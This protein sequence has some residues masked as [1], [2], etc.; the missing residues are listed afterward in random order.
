MLFN[1]IEYLVFLPLVIVI[2]FIIP[3]KWRWL[4]LLVASYFFYMCNRIEYGILILFTTLVDYFVALKI[5]QSSSRKRKKGYLAI[6]LIA[7]LGMLAGFKYLNFFGESV[8]LLLDAFHMQGNLPA[9]RIL[10][11]VGIS[12]FVFKSL[13]YTIDVYRGIRT[14]EKHL[15]YYALYVSFFPQLIAGP[16]DRSSGLLQQFHHP[17]DFNT[18]RLISGLK[19]ILWGFFKKVII[20]D[21]LGL[22]V[23]EI[24]AHPEA[25]TGLSVILATVLFAFQLYCDFAGYTDIA[26]GSARILGFDLMIN[27]NRPM[28]AR[29]LRDF[30]NRW[31]ISLTTWFRDYVLYSL[32][33]IKNKQVSYARLYVNLVI[34]YLLMGL[35]HGAAW[36]FVIF[37]ALNGMFLV[38]ETITEKQRE[39][40]FNWSRLNRVHFLNN[41][42]SNIFT[43]SLI[44]FT[45]IFFRADSLG[46]SL[47][48]ISNSFDF[49]NLYPSLWKILHDNELLFGI[50]VLVN[51][52]VAE[53]VHEKQD[54]V[55]IIA[56]KHIVVRWAVYIGF[57]FFIILFW[58]LQKQE[59]I[60]F[61]F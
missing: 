53:H 40:F 2:Y 16:I 9:F 10:L 34:T 8:N 15:G 30:W 41:F 32:P 5:E 33:Y 54:L 60:Y 28:V 58:V 57:I 56:S 47:L 4:F 42:L 27:F 25:Y 11:P 46:N 1:S 37:G 19:L 61:Q 24:F 23:D 13:S 48:I 17:R 20:A 22:Y 59:F 35:W 44:I 49:S 3:V 36:N 43:L 14:P 21:R 12:F 6:S 51:M 50:L 31:H 26:R 29:S 39:W 45:L 38:L 7:N 52:M 55:K 18:D